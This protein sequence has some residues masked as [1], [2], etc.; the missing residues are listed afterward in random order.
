MSSL[1]LAI[2]SH[3]GANA[4]I[5]VHWPFYE[6]SGADKIIGIGTTDGRCQWPDGVEHVEIGRDG[7]IDG[8]HLPRKLLDTMQFMLL[9]PYDRYCLIEWDCLFFAPLP[10]FTGMAAF[11]AGNRSPGMR[12][13][14]FWHCPWSWDWDTGM[15]F[16]TKGRDLL[17]RVS[18]HECSPDV[19]FGWV[20][21]EAGIPVSQ[22]WKG[23]S[24]NSLDCAGDVELA[25]KA[26][27]AGAV[28][29]HG[30]KRRADLD[31]VMS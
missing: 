21:E 8:D 15:S 24:R 20:C 14:R 23:F 26:R 18:G 10:E 12:A 22:P 25:R 16:L 28:A 31:Y 5:P 19:F 13:Q 6:R 27:M 3:A 4:R 2:H 29:I 7:Y 17:R 11:H 1:L 9:L 30:I